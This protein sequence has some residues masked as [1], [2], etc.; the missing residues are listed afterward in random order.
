MK[1]TI[2]IVWATLILLSL[3][4]FLLGYLEFIGTILVGF[5]LLST[6]IKGVLVIDYF[7]GLKEIQLR[8]RLIPMVWLSIVL[9]LI[10][11]AYYLPL[12]IT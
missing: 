3:F 2:E 8:Y 6:F 11:L 10:A 4:A 1:K 12:S 7:M 5:L 9:S